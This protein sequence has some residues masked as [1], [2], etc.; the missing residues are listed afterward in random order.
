VELEHFGTYLRERR[1][2][3]GLSIAELSRATKIKERAL[4]LL[5]EGRLDALPA[6]VFVSGFVTAYA[7]AI[8]VDSADVMRRYSA[9]LERLDGVKEQEI[10]PALLA[11]AEPKKP[12]LER[13]DMD[14]KDERGGIFSELFGERRPSAA[15][16][17]LLVVIVATLTLSLLLGRGPAHGPGLSRLSAPPDLQHVVLGG[18]EHQPLGEVV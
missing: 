11:S 2:A 14:P 8:G 4:E 17:V 7:R 15:L 5:E 13:V 16:V 6:R 1:R 10:A 12:L 3:L 18:G 9:H